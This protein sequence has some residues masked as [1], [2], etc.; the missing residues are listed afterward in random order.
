MSA[1]DVLSGSLQADSVVSAS[2][3]EQ[4]AGL[5]SS[6]QTLSGQSFLGLQQTMPGVRWPSRL[7]GAHLEDLRGLQLKSFDEGRLQLSRLLWYMLHSVSGQMLGPVCL[8]PSQ[9]TLCKIRGRLVA[10]W[11]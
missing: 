8:P 3:L 10:G 9:E 7:P 2:E 4:R 6:N 11:H 5:S 1:V